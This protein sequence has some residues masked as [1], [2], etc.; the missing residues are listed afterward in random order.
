M[1][2]A[3]RPC[4]QR[5]WKERVR[6]PRGMGCSVRCDLRR[7]RYVLHDLRVLFRTQK[8]P[9]FWGTYF[10]LFKFVLYPTGTV[11]RAA[12]LPVFMD[13]FPHVSRF[14]MIYPAFED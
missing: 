2:R 12:L 8:E 1:C 13:I 9:A 7:P 4:I 14:E 6:L 11:L 3:K 10:T 5:E